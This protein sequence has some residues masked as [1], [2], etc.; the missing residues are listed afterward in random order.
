M[1]RII[2]H[3]FTKDLERLKREVSLFE[4]E[5]NLW[6]TSGSISNSSGNLTL[7]LI[8][9]LNH[10]IGHI[11]GNTNYVRQRS[12]EF[13]SKNVSTT[14]ILQLI[15]DTAVTLRRTFTTIDEQTLNELYP[16]QVF[17]NEELTVAA[18]LLHLT[19]HLNYHLG[20]INYLRRVLEG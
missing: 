7:H 17:K 15:D 18:M 9:N 19:N 1:I 5:S 11:L 13:E 10:F 3:Q 16:I 6:K 4:V 12:A 8:G 2:Q 14:E 20:Q